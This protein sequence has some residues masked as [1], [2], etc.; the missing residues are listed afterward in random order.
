ME[1]AISEAKIEENRSESI[2]EGSA[3]NRLAMIYNEY[4]A[5]LYGYLLTITCSGKDA[6]DLLQELFIRLAKSKFENKNIRKLKS[7]LF[8]CARNLALEHIRKRV[9]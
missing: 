6:E 3:T 4:A 2:S 9:R 5:R 1:I 7:Y 8:T